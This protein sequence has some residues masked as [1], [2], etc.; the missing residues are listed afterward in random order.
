MARKL[1][2][3]SVLS[4]ALTAQSTPTRVL[5]VRSFGARGDGIHNDTGAITDALAA[6]ASS[7]GSTVLLSAPGTYLSGSLYLVSHTTFRVARGA[8]LLGSALY[9][10]YPFALFP[11]V[12][13]PSATLPPSTTTA[14]RG[15]QSLLA[16]AR[17]THETATGCDAWGV[18]TNVTIDGGGVID[19]QGEAWWWADDAGSP[20]A[21]LRPDMVQPYL[22][23]GLTIRDVTLRRSPAWTVHPTLC[24]DV[25]ITGIT[26]ESGQFDQAPQYAGHNVDGVDPD[27]CTNVV[28]ENSL[29]HAGD[30]CIAIYSNHG[31]TSYVTIRNVTCHTPI[32]IT[33]GGGG[34]HGV[35]VDNC[36]V[37]G[38]W[39]GDTT[40][41]PQWWKTALR[42]KTD[43]NTNG[44]VEN[45]VYRNVRAIGVDLLIDIQSWY[46][47][48]NQSGM[49]NYMQ[50]RSFYNVKPGVRPHIRNITVRDSNADGAW[51]S[52]WLNCL[53]ESPCEDVHFI[54]VSAAHALPMMCENVH[55]GVEGSPTLDGQHGCFL[56]N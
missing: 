13:H 1:A 23:N 56:A 31:P 2:V 12:V 54:N 43:R 37:H 49:A 33:H 45:V 35:L 44:T 17:C 48:Q 32:S 19:G 39:G 18:L 11:T 40:Y 52:A 41:K 5:D 10:D 51:R 25:L 7:P 15:R 14:S 3:F 55:G 27:S 22:V 4:F 29:I 6:A 50:C 46:P 34:T 38:D 30:D 24:T 8:T 36:T 16:G 9:T 26:L 42:I 47:C 20:A 28:I 21:H 53:P